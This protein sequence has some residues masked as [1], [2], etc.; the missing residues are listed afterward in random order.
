MALIIL[1]DD[2]FNNETGKSSLPFLVDFW[3]VWCGP[4]KMLGPIVEELTD[5][6]QGKINVG[7][8][9]VDENN[10]TAS[11]FGIMSIPTIAIFNKGVLV[12]TMIGLHDKKELRAEI[13]KLL[14]EGGESV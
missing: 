10:Q 11:R 5:E 9:D 14:L 8:L 6:Y 13:D 12:K 4:C 3:A 7:K 1:T 2:N